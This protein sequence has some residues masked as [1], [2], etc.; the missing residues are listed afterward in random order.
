M[1]IFSMSKVERKKHIKRIEE[2]L[3]NYNNYKIA[4]LNIKKQL[5]FI[6]SQSEKKSQAPS[7]IVTSQKN[8]E[9]LRDELSNLEILMSSIDQSLAELTETERIFIECRYFKKWSVEKSAMEIGYSGKALFGIRNQV[10]DKL[11]ISLGGVIY[12]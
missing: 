10:M 11:I 8:E 3:K 1:Y 9:I 4:I 12:I 7:L 2:H 5:E 6:T